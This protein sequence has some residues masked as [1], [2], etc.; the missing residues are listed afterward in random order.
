MSRLEVNPSPGFR[1]HP[2]H[3]ITIEPFGGVVNVMFRDVMIASTNR[4]K[5]LREKGHDP[6]LYLP[7]EDIYFVHLE[8]T[9]TTT[10]CPFKGDASYWNVNGQDEAE[11]HV[12]WAYEHPYDEMREIK[13][14]G[15]FYPD[16]VVLDTDDESWQKHE[17]TGLPVSSS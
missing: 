11:K 9:A 12:M 3:T 2:E 10:H 15:A 16:R 14:Y 4:A 1:D 5:L 17:E 8:K 13:G 6:V 7:F